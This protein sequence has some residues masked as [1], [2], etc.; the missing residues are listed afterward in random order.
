MFSIAIDANRSSEFHV[1]GTVSTI[2]GGLTVWCGCLLFM[3]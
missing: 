3:I 1:A 2:I